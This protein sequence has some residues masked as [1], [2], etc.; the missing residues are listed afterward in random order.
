MANGTTT[1]DRTFGTP[2]NNIK[3]TWSGWVKPSMA[4]EQGL[5][6]G[7]VDANNYAHI[8]LSSTNQLQL[9]NHVSG[10][11]SGNIK[12]NRVLRDCS[13][14]YH[15]VVVF[16]SAVSEATDR[17]KVY[18]NNVRET[19]LGNAVSPGINTASKIN[20]AWSHKVG[21]KLGSYDFSG[22]MSHVN[23]CDGQAYAPSDF[24][25]TD[26]TDGMW[27]IKTSPSVTYGNN[28]FFL[29]LEDSSN[30]DLDSSGNSHTFTTTGTLTA[31][32]DN[33]S[34]NFCTFNSLIG[35]TTGTNTYSNGNTIFSNSSSSGWKQCGGTLAA[36][37]GKYY[38]EV[39]TSTFSSG[40]VLTQF[41]WGA[42]EMTQIT[43][44]LNNPLGKLDTSGGA[45]VNYAPCVAFYDT[46]AYLYSTTSSQDNQVNGSFAATTNTSV[47]M[48]AIDLD[49]GKF[50][51]GK[52]GTWDSISSS[53]PSAGSGGK[54]FTPGG[55]LYSPYVA[56]HNGGAIKANFGN[57]YFGSTAIGS[58]VSAGEGLWKYTP[59]TGYGAFCTK[60]INAA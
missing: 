30:L 40:S 42:T 20:G 51:V 25:E 48:I 12:T 56:S 17:I 18:V 52:D 55:F 58:P 23:F 21:A 19:S 49:N 57:G 5:F 8:G 22:V 35:S 7:Y 16:D 29:K 39:D 1:I 53:N 14:F 10:S 13:A 11:A 38:Y 31:T 44:N 26:A 6:H 43:Q 50:Y 37:K 2:T 33:P 45:L 3:W 47:I 15:I 46:G 41:G 4:Q 54:S 60:N 27:K 24:G 34:N 59:P 9:Y 36:T 28:G 32:K